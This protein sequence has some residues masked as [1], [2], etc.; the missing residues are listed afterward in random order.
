MVYAATV[1]NMATMVKASRWPP[2]S[3]HAYSECGATRVHLLAFCE[4]AQGHHMAHAF[5]VSVGLDCQGNR[6][7]AGMLMS[8]FESSQVIAVV[9]AGTC[10]Q[11]GCAPEAA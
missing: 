11:D 10:C 7:Q 8:F 5:V 6:L 4:R 1:E 3:V 2:V 9:C